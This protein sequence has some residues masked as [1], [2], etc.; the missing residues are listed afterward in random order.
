MVKN[1]FSYL[2]R[3]GAWLASWFSLK[4][5]LLSSKF[6]CEWFVLRW[7]YNRCN[8]VDGL[9]F[10]V[11]GFSIEYQLGSHFNLM[12]QCQSNH[13]FLSNCFTYS[14][15]LS[16]KSKSCSYWNK[17]STSLSRPKSTPSNCSIKFLSYFTVFIIFKITVMQ[18]NSF[19]LSTCL[20]RKQTKILNNI[21]CKT[22]SAPV[23]C[24]LVCS[25]KYKSQHITN[26]LCTW[27]FILWF[28]LV[29]NRRDVKIKNIWC[30]RL[31]CKCEEA[32][33]SNNIEI[34]WHLGTKANLHVQ[35]A[36]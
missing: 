26:K 31:L 3:S 32:A 14:M 12:Y 20:R 28:L 24:I 9:C 30:H 6:K 17:S 11:K 27:W 8:V 36:L 18:L 1:A 23:L 35:N 19:L 21:I 15:G 2:C 22:F 10:P 7:V 13:L 5:F 29:S 34:F 25:K 16:S 4:L 33:V